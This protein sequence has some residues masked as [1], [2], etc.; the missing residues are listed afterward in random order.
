MTLVQAG[1][2]VYDIPSVPR[3]VYDVTG[4]GD[5]VIAIMA[6]SLAAGASLTEAANLA[7]LA[8]GCVVLKFGTAAITPHELLAAV[9]EGGGRRTP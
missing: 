5:T 1:G 3:P 9:R 8:G 7:N 6:L 4:A 2:R